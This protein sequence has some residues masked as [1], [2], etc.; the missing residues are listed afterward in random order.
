MRHGFALLVQIEPQEVIAVRPL[1]PV[2]IYIFMTRSSSSVKA[3]RWTVSGQTGQT[4]EGSA[5][6]S[7]VT[8][9]GSKL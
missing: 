6:D 9:A 7:F 1:G 4:F 8:K 5:G 2:R 3:E